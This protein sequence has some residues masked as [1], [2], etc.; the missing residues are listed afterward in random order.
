MRATC[1]RG[2]KRC[3]FL[4]LTEPRK[5]DWG[6]IGYTF[7]ASNLS[8]ITDIVSDEEGTTSFLERSIHFL[9]VVYVT[10]AWVWCA[11]LRMTVLKISCLIRKD[12]I[13]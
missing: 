9:A 7:A 8:A 10:A 3:R 2:P 4:T 11:E 13:E 5:L 12:Q 6:K 1:S